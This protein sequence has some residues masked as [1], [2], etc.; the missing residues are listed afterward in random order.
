[1]LRDSGWM[2]PRRF[3]RHEENLGLEYTCILGPAA[4]VSLIGRT[5]RLMGCWKMTQQRE[6]CDLPLQQRGGSERASQRGPGLAGRKHRTRR[7][8]R[9]AGVR[10]S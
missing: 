5:G 10:G 9:M 7:R 3:I 6:A 4:Q 1:M 2:V 8:G